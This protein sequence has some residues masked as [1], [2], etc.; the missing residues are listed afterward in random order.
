MLC[1]E[2][3]QK[4]KLISATKNLHPC[5]ISASDEYI[6]YWCR[7]RAQIGCNVFAEK[8]TYS[9]CEIHFRLMQNFTRISHRSKSS[10]D[11][12]R[13]DEK[14]IKNCYP[15]FDGSQAC[16][17][18]N[19]SQVLHRENFKKYI[20][21]VLF[22]FSSCSD[23]ATKVVAPLI[24]KYIFFWNA[25]QI[26]DADGGAE[27]GALL[28]PKHSQLNFLAPTHYTENLPVNNRL[29]RIWLQ[30]ICFSALKK[31]SKIQQQSY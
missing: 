11:V 25:F 7:I 23:I 31:E 26:V 15:G 24:K 19:S 10:L 5:S 1:P 14:S 13:L 18:F 12:H 9:L 27:R 2:F 20:Y 4:K 17:S 29:G 30:R 21:S 6:I 3:E 22:H 28:S 16:N 8:I